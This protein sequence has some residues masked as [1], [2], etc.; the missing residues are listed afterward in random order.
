MAD[1]GLISGEN[2]PDHKLIIRE[3]NFS[4]STKKNMFGIRIFVMISALVFS[5]SNAA[6]A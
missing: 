3:N 6:T 4:L 1:K 5:I 2:K